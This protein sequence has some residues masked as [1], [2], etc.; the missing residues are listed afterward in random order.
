MMHP[1]NSEKSYVFKAI[2]SHSGWLLRPKNER[3]SHSNGS[4]VTSQTSDFYFFGQRIHICENEPFL[5]FQDSIEVKFLLTFSLNCGPSTE[6]YKSTRPIFLIPLWLLLHT[7][8][9]GP[10]QL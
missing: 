1:Q 6:A 2:G 9:S 10:K 7:K 5:F 4:P 8:N 3:L